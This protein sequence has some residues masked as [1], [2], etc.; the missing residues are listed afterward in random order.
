MVF[1][2]IIFQNSLMANVTEKRVVEMTVK[3]VKVMQAAP[4]LV[5]DVMSRRLAAILHQM[6]MKLIRKVNGLQEMICLQ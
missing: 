3:R 4:I 2:K 1:K 6:R 5:A